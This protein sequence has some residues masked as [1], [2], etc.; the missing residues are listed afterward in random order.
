MDNSQCKSHFAILNLHNRNHVMESQKLTFKNFYN[1]SDCSFLHMMVGQI[2]LLKDQAV[3][4]SVAKITQMLSTK[5]CQWF[6]QLLVM[7][8]GV[9]SKET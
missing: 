9:Y 8:D 1:F 5:L 7:T 6:L 4:E 3:L 2:S